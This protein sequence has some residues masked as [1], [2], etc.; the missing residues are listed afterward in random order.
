MFWVSKTIT[1]NGPSSN[2]G[3][4]VSCQ[5]NTA[6][7]GGTHVTNLVR[8]PGGPGQSMDAHFDPAWWFGT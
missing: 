2:S 5:V 6:F 8:G 1:R 4:V 7:Q 3:R